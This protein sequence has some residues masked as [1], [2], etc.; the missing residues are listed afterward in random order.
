M[1]PARPGSPRQL[2]RG[3]H[4]LDAETVAAQQRARL[5]EAVVDLLAERGYG[6][7]T[8]KDLTNAA[9]ISTITFYD[10]FDG[11]P[12]LVLD[13]CDAIIASACAT[14]QARPVAGGELRDRLATVLTAVV[15]TI[16]ARPD[17]AR[18]VLVEVAAVGQLGLARR[19]SLTAGLHDL[20]RGAATVDGSP[21]MSDAALTVLA[22]GTLAVFD[23][24]LRAG[25][26]RP[27]RPAAAELAA[28]GAMY[29]TSTPRPLPPPRAAL[30][31]PQPGGPPSPSPLPRGRHGLPPGYVRRHQRARI[32]E[33]VLQV[34][35]EHGFEA[36]SVRELLVAAGVSTE[37]FYEHFA[38]KEE[39][40]AIAFDQAFVELFAAVW[41]AAL[42]E[43][44]RTA[45]VTSGVDAALGLLSSD[46]GHAR[47]LLADAPS[48]GRPG[49]P[50]IDDA[51]RAFTRL[52]TGATAGPG[53]PK[54]VPAAIVAG[55]VELLAGW[56]LDG[57][58]GQLP[59]LHA[60]LVEVIL[61]PP[62][63]LAAA[64]RAAD[65][66]P[67][68]AEPATGRDDRRLLMDAFAQAVVRDGL[69]ATRLPDVAQQAGVELDVANALFADE[70]DAAT[71]TLNAWAG[72]LVVIA[73]GAFL[74]AAG[75]PPLA[76]HRALEAALHHI[77]RTPALS[78]LVVTDEPGLVPAVS[79]MRT[80][81]ISLFFQ[82]IA[83][84]VPA[85]DQRA[86]QPLATLEV[87]LDGVMAVLR[88]YAQQDRIA[89]LPGELPTL[90]LQC[91]TPF[92]GAD[93]A[94]RV[95]GSPA[96]AR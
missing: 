83:V 25:R 53:V 35:A 1:T 88:R 51:L 29:E 89:E 49:L 79:A 6:A 64:G 7:T 80:R 91:L 2:P 42:A 13:A 59:E 26:L 58:T 71:Q 62:L 12:E 19:R 73:A 8:V 11:K 77:A 10:L 85:A 90:G 50:A 48:A 75:D 40:W 38:S 56:V 36:A 14:L 74:T 17:A 22:G 20:L 87:V 28:W 16:L 63:G 9:G 86:G 65:A 31:P 21:V 55:I 45:K 66:I 43:A 5:H 37:A 23:G 15:E 84:Q 30:V 41:H 52:A 70:L 47:L 67:S 32:L 95:A 33:A 46:P 57:R 24:H 92:F 34:S 4:T 61:T 76:A 60:P 39:A 18:L 94:R 27:L 82:L 72:Q 93:E 81:Y 54:L 96:A 69:A 3:R 78:A 44:D 68:A